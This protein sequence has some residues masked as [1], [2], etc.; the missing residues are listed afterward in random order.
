MEF[1]TES[2]MGTQVEFNRFRW[3]S[4]HE[5]E[6]L[7]DAEKKEIIAHVGEALRF[8]RIRYALYGKEYDAVMG[9]GMDEYYI[10]PK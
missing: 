9:P 8:L 1:Y 4:P 3:Q 2:G 5:Q 6:Q 10:P 7:S